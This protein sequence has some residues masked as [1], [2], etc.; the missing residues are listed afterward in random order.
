MACQ[1]NCP[2][3]FKYLIE[4]GAEINPHVPE[5]YK[6]YQERHV[7][8]PIEGAIQGSLDIVNALVETCDSLDLSKALNIAI[9]KNKY[10]IMEYL[11]SKGAELQLT[12]NEIQKQ[13]DKILIDGDRRII[14]FLMEKGAS[15]NKVKNIQG[16]FLAAIKK[17]NLEKI[18]LLVDLGVRPQYA[19]Q[20]TITKLIG[21]GIAFEH[22]SNFTPLHAACYVY[23]YDIAKF[24]IDL[25]CDKD[26]VDSS[27]NTPDKYTADY[28]IKRLF[29]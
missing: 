16:T 2:D 21:Y 27:G 9:E 28:K 4:N 25:G 13:F 7:I 14:L 1:Y 15:I 23:D 22:V 5:K 12:E 19:I 6:Q 8:Y 26:A 18:K 17:D 10:E 11:F 3:V 24:L 20:Y 29:Q